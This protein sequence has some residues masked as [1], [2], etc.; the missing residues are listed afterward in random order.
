[1]TLNHSGRQMLTAVVIISQGFL[2]YNR[3]C[4]L[5]YIKQKTMPAFLTMNI[6]S[7]THEG[8]NVMSWWWQLALMH[9][10]PAC[11]TFF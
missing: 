7:K 11:S 2:N 1:M 5:R 3:K 4:V 8:E 10:M 9:T 6:S